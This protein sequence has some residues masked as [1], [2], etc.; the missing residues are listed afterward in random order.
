M[1]TGVHDLIITAALAS[2]K[3]EMR[4]YSRRRRT[5]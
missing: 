5:K 4:G 1:N 3:K 2:L